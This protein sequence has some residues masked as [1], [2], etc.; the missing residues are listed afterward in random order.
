ME[1]PTPKDFVWVAY[2]RI[3]GPVR[4]DAIQCSE[5]PYDHPDSYFNVVMKRYGP[6]GSQ[7]QAICACSDL[8]FSLWTKDTGPGSCFPVG[9]FHTEA[10]IK[11]DFYKYSAP[12]TFQVY[13]PFGDSKYIAEE[14]ANPIGLSDWVYDEHAQTSSRILPMRNPDGS[15][16]V[17]HIPQ[18]IQDLFRRDPT[19]S[20]FK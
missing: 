7:Y 5:F 19:A 14:N 16:M 18:E 13:R 10:V 2:V 9:A 11:N 15:E 17:F 6:F 8:G 3:L 4:R 1:Y 12:H 20:N